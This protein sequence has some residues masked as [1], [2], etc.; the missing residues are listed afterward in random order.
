MTFPMQLD[1]PRLGPATRAAPDCAVV[2]LHGLGA[3]G[4]D[5]IGLA[6]YLR[7]ALPTAQFVAPDAPFPCDMAPYGRQW[8]S[9]QDRSP[10][11]MLAGVRAAA[12]VLDAFLDEVLEEYGLPA[13]RLALVGFS[14][15]TMMSLHVAPRRTAQ[16]AGVV[17]FSG[18][19]VGGEALAA[20]IET[21]PPTLL[22]HG[23][24]DGIVPVEASDAAAVGLDGLGV[25]VRLVVRPG[26]GHSIDQQG[27][28]EATAFLRAALPPA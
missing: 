7:E 3:D 1:G 16:L 24:A 25:P 22:V 8:F 28:A 6:P 9:L 21:R 27:L 26:L 13:S 5:L 10:E 20:E 18:A 2:L 19:L 14:Q 15:G 11:R 17:G 4:Q 23:D 12:P